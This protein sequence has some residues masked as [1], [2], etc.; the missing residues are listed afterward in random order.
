VDRVLA[1][2]LLAR[3][4]ERRRNEMRLYLVAADEMICDALAL[5]RGGES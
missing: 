4:L 2:L 5:T 3:E 1:D